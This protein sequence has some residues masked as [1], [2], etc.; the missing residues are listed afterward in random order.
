[1]LYLFFPSPLVSA[2]L[3][4]SKIMLWLINRTNSREIVT[5]PSQARQ[6][7]EGMVD[8][9][10]G[11]GINVNIDSDQHKTTITLITRALV[12]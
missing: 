11:T 7:K 8:N 3:D 2:R 4:S 5:F 1:M 12:S 6:A 10:T 9:R